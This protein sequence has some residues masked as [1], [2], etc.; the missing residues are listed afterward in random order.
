MD[1]LGVVRVI[2]VGMAIITIYDLKNKKS[3][4]KVQFEIK[5][6]SNL[7]FLENKKEILVGKKSDLFVQAYNN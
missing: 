6:V 5:K 7:N 3:Y 1:V 4:D 2:S